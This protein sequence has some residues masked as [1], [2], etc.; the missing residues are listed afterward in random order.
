MSS[1]VCSIDDEARP[2][3]K[4]R[5]PGRRVEP[6]Q[7]PEFRES[8]LIGQVAN[9]SSSIDYASKETIV[10]SAALDTL[11]ALA[12]LLS[13]AVHIALARKR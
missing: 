12:V 13:I 8:H 3:A 2:D 10:L 9:R 6:E 4:R 7:L 5:R 11:G 1:A